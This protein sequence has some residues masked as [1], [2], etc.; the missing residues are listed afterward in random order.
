MMLGLLPVPFALERLE[1]SQLML[2]MLHFLMGMAGKV[3][4]DAHDNAPLD[5]E[6]LER[7]QLMS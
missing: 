6:R 5:W 7:S 1:S 4:A 2:M 3:P